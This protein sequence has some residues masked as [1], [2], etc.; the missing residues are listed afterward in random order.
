MEWLW[1]TGMVHGC[2]TQLWNMAMVQ[3]FGAGLPYT[4]VVPGDSAMLRCTAGL[5]PLEGSTHRAMP[6]PPGR[7]WGRA[8]LSWGAQDR[9]QTEGLL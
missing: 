3:G 7:L 8:A 4:A 1:D 9:G 6:T 2:G 5:V